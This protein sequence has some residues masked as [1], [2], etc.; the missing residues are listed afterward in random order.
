MGK[1]NKLKTALGVTEKVGKVADDF[2]LPFAGMV[3]QVSG[4]IGDR[5]K[6]THGKPEEKTTDAQLLEADLIAG[7]GIATANERMF[8]YEKRQLEME[9]SLGILMARAGLK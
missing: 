3:S 9:K 8:R 6:E 4:R 7:Q 1:W 5:I 2:G